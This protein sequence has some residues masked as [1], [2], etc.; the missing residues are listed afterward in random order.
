VRRL[1]WDINLKALEFGYN[2]FEKQFKIKTERV[3]K[4]LA[5]GFE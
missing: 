4:R 5:A 1:L 3:W 2:M